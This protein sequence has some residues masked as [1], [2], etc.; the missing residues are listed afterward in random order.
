MLQTTLQ[1]PFNIMLVFNNQTSIVILVF[2]SLFSLLSSSYFYDSYRRVYIYI[3]IYM[4]CVLH[5]NVRTIILATT[6]SHL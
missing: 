5:E 4:D 2:W 3:Y 1:L 6:C